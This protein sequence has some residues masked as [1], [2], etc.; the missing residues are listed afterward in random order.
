LYFVI[1][2]IPSYMSAFL[3]IC[4]SSSK[5]VYLNTL[6]AQSIMT[7]NCF[8][9]IWTP[10]HISNLYSGKGWFFLGQN[11]LSFPIYTMPYCVLI[12]YFTILPNNCYNFTPPSIDSV[13]FRV[14]TFCNYS[15][16]SML[17]STVVGILIG[18]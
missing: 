5:V 14:T 12:N 1:T 3:V 4:K 11:N 2:I 9:T 15:P 13:Y 18:E 8:Y 7:P 10:S 6:Y 16:S 17:P